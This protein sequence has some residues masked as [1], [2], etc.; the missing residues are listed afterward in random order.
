[1]LPLLSNNN[2]DNVDNISSLPLE[3]SVS[4]TEWNNQT[5][6]KHSVDKFQVFFSPFL[7]YY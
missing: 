5:S 2:S 6:K 4:L 3:D 7:I 1:M